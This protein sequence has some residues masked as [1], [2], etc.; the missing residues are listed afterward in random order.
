M[1]VKT[2]SVLAG[3]SVPLI[4]AGSSD[5][6]FVGI[7]TTAKPNAFNLYVVNV[8]AEFD[9]PGNDWMEVV[10]GGGGYP[11][12]IRVVGGSLWFNPA[13]GTD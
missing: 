11:L 4:L 2:L 8:Y 6:G 13:F 10:G 9:N 1:K 3:V 5:A 7:T 12:S